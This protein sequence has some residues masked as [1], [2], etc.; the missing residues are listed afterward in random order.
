MCI[1]I[2]VYTLYQ[3]DK[4]HLPID[5][6][7]LLNQKEGLWRL[8]MSILQIKKQAAAVIQHKIL[9]VHRV[10]SDREDHGRGFACPRAKLVCDRGRPVCVPTYYD[11]E[12]THLFPTSSS[13]PHRL[14]TMQLHADGGRPF[15][16]PSPLGCHS[17]VAEC[18]ATSASTCSRGP[19]GIPSQQAGCPDS[20]NSDEW[21]QVFLEV[22]A[23][24]HLLCTFFCTSITNICPLVSPRL[25]LLRSF[26]STGRTVANETGVLDK[27]VIMSKIGVLILVKKLSTVGQA[28]TVMDLPLGDSWEPV[29]LDTH[30]AL[31]CLTLVFAKRQECMKWSDHVL[32]TSLFS[33]KYRRAVKS[34]FQR[35]LNIFAS[36]AVLIALKKSFYYTAGYVY[37]Y[38]YIRNVQRTEPALSHIHLIEGFNC[39]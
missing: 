38:V 28:E 39:H 3:T 19:V 25:H 14:H 18:W 15:L 6:W 7:M 5:F 27:K 37:I 23:L 9:W 8:G 35:P 26:C 30:K 12:H 34:E 21:A 11:D 33:A 29:R 17:V 22:C 24:R 1:H 16:P 4:R 31:L 10:S 20:I 13:L 36:H 2:S 32:A